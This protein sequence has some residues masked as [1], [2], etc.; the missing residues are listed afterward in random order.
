MIIRWDDAV[1]LDWT[2]YGRLHPV[3]SKKSNGE[4]HV[5]GYTRQGFDICT[6]VI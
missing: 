3:K 1:G 2:K 5:K 4:A 6:R